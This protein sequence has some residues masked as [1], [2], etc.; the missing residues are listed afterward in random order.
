M[1]LSRPSSGSGR[2]CW[3]PCAVA[4]PFGR[5]AVAYV[6]LLHSFQPFAKGI[7]IYGCIE[8]DRIEDQ[9]AEEAARARREL[10]SFVSGLDLDGLRYDVR[11]EEGQTFYAI[12][13]AIECERPDLLV[14]GTRGLTGTK[15]VLLGS[16]ADE[17]GRA[18]V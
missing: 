5:P 4:R 6:T 16:V 9:V 1:P 8:R 18:N 11:L 12:K 14:L 10:T 15:R 2:T 13:Q 7:M 17:I 3:C